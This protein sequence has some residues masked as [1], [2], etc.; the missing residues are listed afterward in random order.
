MKRIPGL[1][2]LL[3]AGLAVLLAGCWGSDKSASLDL[4]AAPQ[5]DNLSAAFRFCTTCH[6]DL[7]SHS[8]FAIRS[9]LDTACTDC[10]R[11]PAPHVSGRVEV[12][13]QW[14]ESGHGDVTAL[15]WT[16]DDFK[17]DAESTCHRCHTATGYERFTDN[18]LAYHSSDYITADNAAFIANS[19]TGNLKEVLY[20][21]GCH[22]INPS[23]GLALDAPRRPVLNAYLPRGKKKDY[24]PDNVAKAGVANLLAF[25][26]SQVGDSIL[27][28]NCHAG[29]KAAAHVHNIL[30]DN[31][32]KYDN[33]TTFSSFNVHYLSAAQSLYQDNTFDPSYDNVGATLHGRYVGTGGY[34]FPDL[35]Q[36]LYT[37]L[38]YYDHKYI[39][40]TASVDFPATDNSKGPCVTCHMSSPDVA[41]NA[42]TGSHS[43]FPVTY[44]DNGDIG[45]ITSPYCANCHAGGFALTPALLNAFKA[46]V[47]DNLA[48]L[49]TALAARGI[50]YDFAAGRPY[51]YNSATL[52][53]ASSG[54]TMWATTATAITTARVGVDGGT[55][56]AED[57]I[58]VC[59][60][61]H[62][63]STEAGSWV[64][65][66]KYTLRLIYDS[67]VKMGLSPGFTRP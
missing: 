48:R 16:E 67:F 59:Y 38:S 6:G 12:N 15:P 50:Y 64:H 45:A 11:D 62:F 49:K 33:V 41:G 44:L 43:F 30:G 24:T 40:T 3:A 35:A 14:R 61:L 13:R 7:P 39:G 4:A 63:L 8:A 18:Q 42:S 1:S 28:I 52:R 10:H 29:R 36:A 56:T 57:L 17:S 46:E 22:V 2:V 37:P 58:G 20:C 25:N 27:C 51:F 32:A 47:Q 60:N 19:V 65:N 5:A 21:R 55:T 31:T 66:N 54:F 23:T 34:Q 9:N 26:R 53:D